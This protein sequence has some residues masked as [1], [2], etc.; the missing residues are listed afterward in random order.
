LLCTQFYATSDLAKLAS[1]LAEEKARRIA[2]DQRI[3][4]LE[5]GWQTERTHMASDMADSIRQLRRSV[6][7]LF[8]QHEEQSGAVEN[9]VN[10]AEMMDVGTTST[11]LSST[12]D[13]SF[14]THCVPLTPATPDHK[15]DEAISE[16]RE[17]VRQL[18]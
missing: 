4:A 6:E 3:D 1:Q 15:L 2:N 5:R 7:Q 11:Y 17:Q 16:L 13:G 12:F 18:A 10:L 9:L 8:E 14:A